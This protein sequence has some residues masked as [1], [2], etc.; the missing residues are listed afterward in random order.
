MGYIPVQSV[1]VLPWATYQ[2]CSVAIGYIPVQAV[3]P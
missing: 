3:L 1:S 2:Q